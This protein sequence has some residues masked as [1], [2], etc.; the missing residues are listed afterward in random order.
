MEFEY[1]LEMN[2]PGCINTSKLDDYT[3]S[4]VYA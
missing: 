4:L 3:N 2:R 1:A